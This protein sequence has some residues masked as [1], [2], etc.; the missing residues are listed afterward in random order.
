MAG[1]FTGEGRGVENDDESMMWMGRLQWNF[2]GRDLKWRQ[3]D[4][5]YTEKPTGSL[6]FAAATNKGRCTR[7]SSGGCGNLD[8]FTRASAAS[9]GQFKVEQMVQEFAFKYRGLSL[10]EEFHWK[11]VADANAGTKNDLIG[12]YGQAGYFLHN[13]FPI[14]PAPLELAFRY[15]FVEEPNR[16]DRALANYRQEYTVGANWFIWGH[17]NKV[18]VDYSHLEPEDEFLARDVSDDRVRIQWDVSF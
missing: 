17:N 13:L 10:Q 18:T 1:V 8:G 9:P 5:E 3:T 12:A 6:A 7:W 16:F 2:L 11:T 15:A 14:V 4:V